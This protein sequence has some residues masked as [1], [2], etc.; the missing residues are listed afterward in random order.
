MAF[1]IH[2]HLNHYMTLYTSM[3]FTVDFPP[4]KTVMYALVITNPTN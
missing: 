1:F 2:R 3:I 4:M